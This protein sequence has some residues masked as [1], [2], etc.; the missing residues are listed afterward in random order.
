MLHLIRRGHLYAGLLLIPWVILFG[1]TGFLFNHSTFWPEQLVI[2]VRQSHT[3]GTP[4]ASL[5]KAVDIA[6][7]VVSG[8]NAK[9]GS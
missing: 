7:E 3:R 9:V 6:E 5:P 8:I 1:V 4:V 2:H